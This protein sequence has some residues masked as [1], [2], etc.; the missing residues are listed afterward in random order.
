MLVPVAGMLLAVA[1]SRRI[2]RLHPDEA[3]V[4]RWLV[5]AVVVKLARLVLPLPHD[6]QRLR[7]RRDATGYDQYGRRF[8]AAWL[9]G[10][11]APDLTDLRQ[12]NFL[13]WF[14]GVVYYLFGSNMVAGFFVFGL[15]ALVGS[16]LWYRATVDAVPQVDKRLYLALVLFAPSV[17]FWPSSIGK[18][19][20]MQLGIGTVAL[21]TAYL[22]RQRLA[23]AA[24][25]GFA[26]GWLLWVVRPHLLALVTLAAGCAYVG[27][28]VR[29]SGGPMRSLMARPVACSRW[30][31]WWRS[32]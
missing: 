3:W 28:R 10:G 12:T 1:A 25:I 7:R 27:G 4:G 9:D 5:L 2:A 15:L 21:A 16:Y 19:S 14:T 23:R 18:E 17:A 32:P 31:S 6:R 8:A 26:G 11:N 13:R 30:C 29:A 20:L 24:V 22:L